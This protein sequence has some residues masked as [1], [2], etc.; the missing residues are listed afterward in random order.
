MALKP[1]S[2][3]FTKMT[4]YEHIYRIKGLKEHLSNGINFDNQFNQSLIFH[5]FW[6][7]LPISYDNSGSFMDSI[8]E[9]KLDIY[10]TD[11]FIL[12][13]SSNG[14][15]KRR[16]AVCVGD[17]AVNIVSMI[18]ESKLPQ[19][20]TSKGILSIKDKA[21]KIT[22][23]EWE[24]RIKQIRNDDNLWNFYSNEFRAMPIYRS[25]KLI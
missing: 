7:E 6:A 25:I 21:N 24:N 11:G 1:A 20:V 23:E 4:E 10:T 5:A 3:V 18:T 12:L 17:D 14:F 15:G 16:G 8:M 13:R 2:S 22:N 9:W 19:R